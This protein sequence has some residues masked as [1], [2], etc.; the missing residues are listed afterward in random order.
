MQN[1]TL[2]L[3]SISDKI[4][5]QRL[6]NNIN[7][8]KNLRTGFPHPYTLDDA[9]NFISKN[10]SDNNKAVV[11]AMKYNNEFAGI[12]G[13]HN[14]KDG[15]AELG[16]WLGELYWGKGITTKA[17]NTMLN[18]AINQFKL[19]Q[20]YAYCLV[21]NVGSEKVLLNCGFI[22]LKEVDEGCNSFQKGVKSYYFEYDCS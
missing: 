21:N 11:R 14:I 4:P 12:I 13:L 5:L 20:V 7:I 1:V 16:Y 6:A 9:A 10:Q 15:R 2:S 17:V 22:K 3:L 18:K 8:A 19:Q